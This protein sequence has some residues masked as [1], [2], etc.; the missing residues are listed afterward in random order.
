MTTP[1]NLVMSMARPRHTTLAFTGKDVTEFLE[2]FNRQADNG[3]VPNSLRVSIL[4]DYLSDTDRSISR[5]L[6][7]LP[8]YTDKDWARLQESMKDQWQDEDTAIMMGKRS[9]LQAYIHSCLR[10]WPG[11]A[12]YYTHFSSAADACVTNKQVPEGEVGIMFFKGL[13]RS[14]KEAVM[15]YM[16]DAPNGDDWATY[17][18][19]KMYTFLKAHHKKMHSLDEMHRQER[20]DVDAEMR[21]IML[22][23]KRATFTPESVKE[24]VA[25]IKKTAASPSTPSDVDVE[26][27]DLIKSL[28]DMKLELAT[29]DMLMAHPDTA[30]LLKKPS[31]YA[32]FIAKA[33]TASLPQERNDGSF[34]T[35]APRN[36][37]PNRG[38][39][40]YGG[41]EYRN[42][43][44]M[45]NEAGHQ[46][47]NCDLYNYLKKMGWISFDWDPDTK[48][49][50]YYFGP[51]Q[52]R[53][54]EIPGTPPP[55][56][57]LQW[58]KAKIREFF[59]VT[60]DVLDQPASS[61]VPEKF[62]G[63][64]SRPSMR[65]PKLRNLT[66]TANV[67]TSSD[68]YEEKH[69]VLLQFQKFQD[70]IFTPAQLDEQH[71]LGDVDSEHIILGGGEQALLNLAESNAAIQPRA[72]QGTSSQ[73]IDGVRSGDVRKRGRPAKNGRGRDIDRA[74]REDTPPVDG[75][76]NIDQ[77]PMDTSY[78]T[79]ERWNS[80]DPFSIIK[81]PHSVTIDDNM[82]ADPK[83]LQQGRKRKAVKFLDG[84][85]DVELRDML[86]SN[87]NRIATALLNQ[88]V[89]SITVADLIGQEGIKQ[90]LRNLLDEDVEAVEGGGSVNALMVSGDTESGCSGSHPDSALPPDWP[91]LAD[92]AN[93]SSPAT[94]YA[95]HA[96]LDVN[97]AQCNA[98]KLHNTGAQT[99]HRAS[100]RGDTWIEELD[101]LPAKAVR[102]AHRRHGR[103]YVQSD[104]PE[105]WVTVNGNS[106]KCLIDTGA[107]MNILRL[108][109][110]RAMKIPYEIM[111]QNPSE[112]TQ[113]VTSANGTHDPFVG[114]AF[115]V[116]IRVGSVT[117]FTTFR[118]V[119]NVTRSAILGGPWC[120]C[121]KITIQYNAFGRVTCK[122]VSEDGFRNTVFIASD[123]A[124]HHP[125]QTTEGED[126]DID[127]ENE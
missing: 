71:P 89:R 49:G 112:P 25:E 52:E 35:M 63:G 7:R 47:K 116:P 122:I 8:G 39:A 1:S 102:N 21:R 115:N 36:T 125:S 20:G 34:V 114:T 67:I 29:I 51:P 90:Q 103:V 88:E 11:L 127:S 94:S 70:H 78:N 3:N 93:L 27:E 16:A 53:L 82:S 96:T 87:P 43:C 83:H 80:K 23:N 57:I 81:P 104:L 113:G 28:G 76:S 45:C 85:P 37:A 110:A 98:I 55:N 117:T 56:F 72:K 17:R 33:T 126:E 64:D 2:D 26:V 101:N 10:D 54:G 46:V 14:D 99:R 68:Q 124:P 31:N 109:A 62:P 86:R 120:A 111:Q 123:P 5:I 9:Y 84:L 50:T 58:L 108:S 73:A 121:A 19:D 13:P 95:P 32:Y 15:Y 107:Q 44:N 6:K 4:P 60:D 48:K 100:G 24:A 66:T 65:Y 92:P 91:A 42:T 69:D 41:R 97:N 30:R 59:N 118:L 40:S 79:R 12:E 22:S 18:K 119:A 105:C 74:L 61:V 106:M 75:S 38:T 77:Q